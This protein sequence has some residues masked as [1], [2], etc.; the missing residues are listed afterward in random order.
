MPDTRIRD[1]ATTATTPAD[2]DHAVV[3]PASGATSKITIANLRASMLSGH[4]G[5]GGAAHA[6]AVASG[7]AGFLT[8]ADKAKLDGVAAA[9]AA[10]GAG[11]VAVGSANSDGASASSARVDHVHAH[12][13]QLGGSL[14]A[15]AVASGA[16][17]FMTGSDKAKL[18][19]VEAAAD[20][21]DFANVSTALAAASASVSVNAQRI[22]NVADPSSAQDAATKA[23]V[24]ALAQGLSI[25]QSARVATVANV[26]LSTALENGDSL[27][28]VTLA[29]GDRVLVK[30]QSTASQNGIYVVQAS[31]AAVRATDFDASGD[32]ARGAFVFV[33]EGATHADSGWV[34]TTDGAI[35]VGTTAL[36]FTQFSGAGQITAGAGL[37]KTGNTINAVAHADGS[38]VA[39]ADSLQVGVL[40]TDAQHGN[41][42]G[43][44]LHANASGSAA[45]FMSVAM[46]DKLAAYEDPAIAVSEPGLLGLFQYGAF[47]P[48]AAGD[49]L[50]VLRSN[51]AGAAPSWDTIA[52]LGAFSPG[53]WG[54]LYGFSAS[55]YYEG[56]SAPTT[57]ARGSLIA[58]FRIT[59]TQ[60]VD[61]IVVG[62]SN[63][64]FSSYGAHINV[65]GDT[66]QFS[67]VDSGG[68]RRTIQ[69]LGVQIGK[70]YL[71][72]G[73]WDGTGANLDMRLIVQARQHSN[74]S[75]GAAGA[76]T[77]GAAPL[78]VGA[79]N[80]T[81]VDPATYCQIAMAGFLHDTVL[82]VEDARQMMDLLHQTQRPTIFAGGGV[83]DVLTDFG[84]P[85]AV[86][87]DQAAGS[88]LSEVGSV[89]HRSVIE[90]TG[91]TYTFPL[92]A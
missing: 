10:V 34:L 62:F 32:V 88:S 79:A 3:D 5:T 26:D 36:A 6:N 46:H 2:A 52:N 37:T 76:L 54:Y 50:H 55:N 9:A 25:K 66:V 47:T 14:H 59:E 30:D 51:G 77:T 38:I 92:L 49:D 12:G 67:C 44:G 31:G 18:D 1:L 91:T 87:D 13:D 43:G 83:F 17:G 78:C 74:S 29:T 48:F 64:V 28:G 23:Y 72:I 24:D 45:G 58:L 20:V 68:T 57:G 16:A 89:S 70:W 63:S 35:T 39:N 41:R 8:G 85:G 4:A 71:V 65:G 11:V 61:Q 42:G 53:P 56:A 73:T 69:I 60:F 22:T 21:T 7:A 33:Q 86:W 90:G 84:D 19:G 15:N 81:G 40:A 75:A 82:D 80:G 27:D